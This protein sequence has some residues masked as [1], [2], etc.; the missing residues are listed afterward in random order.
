MKTPCWTCSGI[1]GHAEMF[2]LVCQKQNERGIVCGN[3]IWLAAKTHKQKLN[4]RHWPHK[5]AFVSS[6]VSIARV[7]HGSV[8]MYKKFKCT[9]PTT[10][11]VLKACCWTS[12]VNILCVIQAKQ[13][14]VMAPFYWSCSFRVAETTEPTVES[15][16]TTMSYLSRSNKC[17]FNIGQ[18]LWALHD[19][20]NLFYNMINPSLLI[21]HYGQ[22][23][24]QSSNRSVW[25]EPSHCKLHWLEKCITVDSMPCVPANVSRT[26]QCKKDGAR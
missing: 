14:D 5:T 18:M 7:P 4:H 22:E 16:Y 25:M 13:I 20:S 9:F 8:A 6:A 23:W 24:G 11:N 26:A 12:I 21:C 17:T 1:Q 15:R 3:K 19:Q 10:M 2:S